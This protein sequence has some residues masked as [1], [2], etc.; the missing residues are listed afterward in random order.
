M[1]TTQQLR[2][3]QLYWSPNSSA[4]LRV[5]LA[6]RAKGMSVQ[7]MHVCLPNP[8]PRDGS[9]YVVEHEGSVVEYNTIS[10]EGRI[11]ALVIGTIQGGDGEKRR[12]LTQA[13]AILEYIEDAPELGT[14][15]P[16]LLP[17]DPW[18]R[19]RVRQICWLI[20]ADIHPLQNMGMIGT[21][22]RD[23]G[24]PAA[25]GPQGIQTHPFRVHYL[26]RALSALDGILR[27][28]AEEESIRPGSDIKFCVG[29]AL[30]LAD[31][32]LIPQVRNAIGAGIDIEAEFPVVARVWSH[33]LTLETISSTLKDCGGIAQPYPLAS[34]ARADAASP[35]L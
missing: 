11:P 6:L 10:P 1:S 9:L 35:N 33:C 25:D 34:K 3:W 24:M 21:A 26:R 23:F 20:G 27:D 4:S 19:A 12:L 31:I 18:Q 16:A 14:A 22:I 5:V 29:G 28:I 2:E 32:F 8:N 17:T 13:A 7:N 15:G 30:S